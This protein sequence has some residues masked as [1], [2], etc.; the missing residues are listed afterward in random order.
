MQ[1]KV[2]NKKIGDNAPVFIIAEIGTNHNGDPAMA[3]RIIKAAA[4][5]G[6]DA[7]KIQLVDPDESYAKDSPSYRI[8][9]KV[10][11]PFSALTELKKEADRLNIIFFATAGDLSSLGV[12][13][14]LKM[15]VIKISSGCMTNTPLLRK[16]AGMRLPII[17]STGMAYLDETKSAV[18]ELERN[19]AKD[20]ALLHCTSSYPAEYNEL[21]LNAVKT[22]KDNFKYPIGY[23]DHTKDN[24]ASAAAVSIGASVIEKHF[25]LYKAMWGSDQSVSMEPA[26]LGKLCRA[27]KRL[28]M[29]RGDGIIR[30][31][32]EEIPV[33]H[34]LRRKHG[35]WNFEEIRSRV[36]KTPKE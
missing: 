7:V 26:D 27:V 32:P 33:M 9:K 25:T 21:N 16:A 3:K 34:K 30:I 6:A 17:M 18:R 10:S 31:Y 20:I 29:V 23:S 28:K 13:M 35:I 8:F 14:K 5:A 1:I 19:G 15:T 4:Q 24:L 36:I 22:L 2:K 11:L 12:I